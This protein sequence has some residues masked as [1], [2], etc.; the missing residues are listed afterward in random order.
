MQLSETTLPHDLT[1]IGLAIRTRAEA[2]AQDIPALW[3]RFY[4]EGIAQRL[5]ALDPQIYALYCDYE[6]DFAG[7]YTMVL[8]VA[9]AADA[10]VPAGL[11]RV[12]VPAGRFATLAV[13]GDPA[14]VVG[15][16]WDHI[17]GAWPGKEGRRYVADFE[18]YSR[19]TFGDADA[20]I[21]VGLLA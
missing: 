7:A 14:Q 20:E 21:C 13:S 15:R 16:G 19:V 18:R 8:G 4:Q 12:R 6:S 17:N 3:S 2:T 11:R 1:I 10:A 5:P 9:C